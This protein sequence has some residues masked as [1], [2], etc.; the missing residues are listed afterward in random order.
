[1]IVVQPFRWSFLA[2]SLLALAGCVRS[3]GVGSLAVL[4]SGLLA[5]I[6]AEV[7]V[8]GPDGATVLLQ[9][10]AVLTDLPVGSYTVSAATV[11]TAA[12]SAFVATITGSPA[13]VAVGATAEVSIAYTAATGSLQ[14]EVV[15]LPT[16]VDADVR[17]EGPGGFAVDLT[18]DATLDDLPPG[19]YVLAAEVVRQDDPIVDAIY[20]VEAF[21]AAVS[22]D[23]GAVTAT[24][25]SYLRRGDSGT[26]WI[27]IP[28]ENL[29]DVGFVYGFAAAHLTSSTDPV[30]EVTLETPPSSK[31]DGLAVDGAGRLWALDGDSD[32]LF[33]FDPSDLLVDGLPSPRITITGLTN[34]PTAAAFDDD[35]G[36]W[37]SLQGEDAL[38]HFGADQLAVNGAPTPDRTLTGLVGPTGLAFDG[39]GNLWVANRDARALTAYTPDQLAIGGLQSPVVKIGNSS[40]SL[41]SPTGLAFD[42]AGSLWVANI[43]VDSV[44]RFGAT[45]L[46]TSGSPTPEAVL[47]ASAD[48]L[49]GPMGLALDGS[50]DLWV[51]N[52]FGDSLIRF[53]APASLV[54]KAAPAPATTIAIDGVDAG[55]LV[56][57]PPG[58]ALPIVTP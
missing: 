46:A 52:S 47:V 4:V 15:G 38:I 7:E 37:I 48:S 42:A 33:M 39:A 9:G 10:S 20:L 23:S 22:V 41:D 49:D 45:Q 24:Q 32:R 31:V 58:D 3:P 53:D 2:L 21:E 18:G 29:P 14:V 28:E 5:G 27:P 43:W 1:M 51:T 55:F 34:G 50:G 56:F 36:L 40:D 30:P 16:G 11:T 54:G 19:L 44:V 25:V 12:S 35:G 17:V 26:L 57:A 13:T 8:V 6:D